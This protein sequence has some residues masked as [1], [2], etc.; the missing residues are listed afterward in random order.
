MADET[1]AEM[2]DASNDGRRGRRLG[3]RVMA[4]ASCFFP[5]IANYLQLQG[6]LLSVEIAV[7]ITG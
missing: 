5:E 6:R 2:A 1:D 4:A 7:R 3:V